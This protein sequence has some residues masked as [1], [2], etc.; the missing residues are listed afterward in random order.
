MSHSILRQLCSSL[1]PSYSIYSLV[2]AFYSEILRP[3][4][5]VLL[6]V[7]TMISILAN[8]TVLYSEISSPHNRMSQCT[9][10]ALVSRRRSKNFCPPFQHTKASLRQ[11][12]VV[13]F[14]M[15]QHRLRNLQ[16]ST[17]HLPWG[18]QLKGNKK[19]IVGWRCTGFR[20]WCLIM[21]YGSYNRNNCH[22]EV[23]KIYFVFLK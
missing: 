5:N 20:R 18:T 4:R 22:Q 23:P 13:Y 1:T 17:K 16:D 6:R 7:F 9:R 19:K 14:D 8:T 21:S 10:Q 3:A 11:V 12:R 2:K 15:L